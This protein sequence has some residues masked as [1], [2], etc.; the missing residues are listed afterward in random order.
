MGDLMSDI[1]AGYDLLI[2]E[3]QRLE[4]HDP[5]H[6]LLRYISLTSNKSGFIPNQSRELQ[7]EFLKRFT[8]DKTKV[9]QMWMNYYVAIR[10]AVDQIEGIDREPKKHE[11]TSITFNPSISDEEDLPF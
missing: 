9:F 8:D 5:K 3:Y 1:D 7:S 4:K 2:E 11:L 6:E 10:G